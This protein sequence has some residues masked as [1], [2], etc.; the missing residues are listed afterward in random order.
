M[1]FFELFGLFAARH[2]RDFGR[3]GGQLLQFLAALGQQR[4][5]ILAGA[6]EQGH[7]HAG[8]HR[9]VGG[10]LE[11]V[12]QHRHQVGGRAQ[13]PVGVAQADA[14]VV[15]QRRRVLVLARHAVADDAVEP[16][17]AGI[18]ALDRH[19]GLFRGE[20]QFV[21]L[22]RGHAGGDR[23][24]VQLGI[25]LGGMLGH[26]E[27][28]DQ[29]AGGAEAGQR[30]QEF[31]ERV[32]Q[33]T[34]VDRQRAEMAAQEVDMPGQ[35]FVAV[36]VRGVLDV[37]AGV[38]G[39]LAH[40]MQ[41]VAG[42]FGFLAS[43]VDGAGGVRGA[44][45]GFVGRVMALMLGFA[46]RGLEHM[47]HPRDMAADALRHRAEPAHV[48]GNGAHRSRRLIDGLDGGV[49]DVV[50]CHVRTLP[51]RVFDRGNALRLIQVEREFADGQGQDVV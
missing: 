47:A 41:G 6:T 45:G 28:P 18:H 34:G 23:H 16:E 43:A 31:A 12:G 48:L 8:A 22:R 39:F 46:E 7:R 32:P 17:Q 4:Q 29:A 9:R 50:V 33:L 13:M 10:V 2:E 37:R 36:R 25:A 15:E 38:L 42:L 24:L 19:V 49:E 11:C 30:G 51:T 1:V 44:G 14:E 26:L 5:Q 21:E 40:R 3:F 20:G 35:H 27:Q